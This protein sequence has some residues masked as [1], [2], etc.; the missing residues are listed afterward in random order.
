MDITDIC[1][2]CKNFFLKNGTSDIY[3]GTYTISGGMISPVP[4]SIINGQYIRI[5]GSK[6][7]DRVI[8]YDVA[9]MSELTD[10]IFDGAIWDMS[11]PPSFVKL[12]EDIDNWNEKYSGAVTSPYS[13][14]S[15]KGYSRTLRTSGEYGSSNAL[16]WQN[17]FSKR[18]AQYRRINIF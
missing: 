18:L 13:S 14:E 2:E 15:F 10:E 16:T 4:D 17:T 5:A 1:L 7:N 8:K 9:G 11:V 6:L 12:C 3:P